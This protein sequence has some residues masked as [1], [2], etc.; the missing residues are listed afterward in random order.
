MKHEMI[1]A[2]ISASAARAEQR[3]RE[4][5]RNQ[6]RGMS[7]GMSDERTRSKREPREAQGNKLKS[8]TEFIG[9]ERI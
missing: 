5:E 3:E 7:E 9:Y 1:E 4:R 2:A 6:S 8:A